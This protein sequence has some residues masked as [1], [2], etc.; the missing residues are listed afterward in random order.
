MAELSALRGAAAAAAAEKAALQQE[1]AA[2]RAAL[3][4]RH[5]GEGARAYV[6]GG[7]GGAKEWVETVEAVWPLRGT[8][9]VRFEE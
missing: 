4:Q 8:M 7:C 5:D 3:L 2:A 9:E 1:L 6:F